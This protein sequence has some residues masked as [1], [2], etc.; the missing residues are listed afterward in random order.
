MSAPAAADP[1]YRDVKMTV[2]QRSELVAP[3]VWPL[4]V[5]ARHW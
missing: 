3:A 1:I 4:Q 5:G 2:E